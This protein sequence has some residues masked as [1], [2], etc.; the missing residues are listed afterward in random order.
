MSEETSDPKILS[1]IVFDRSDTD[2]NGKL[3]ANEF[4][5]MCSILGYNLS[6]K[7]LEIGLMTIDKDGSGS[8]SREEFLDWFR[9]PDRRE[10]LHITEDELEKRESAST[11]FKYF[12][13][14]LD[15]S[16]DKSEFDG[17]YEYLKQY[18]LAQVSKEEMIKALDISEDGK[19]QFYEY[20]SFLE[21]RGML[22]APR[23]KSSDAS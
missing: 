17:F 18:N 14:N 21:N 22:K 4:R 12:D 1:E 20:I 3:N 11:A 10:K 15:G 23:P 9:G 19:I 6:P 8:I 7:Q 2:K 5:Y 13:R 16:L